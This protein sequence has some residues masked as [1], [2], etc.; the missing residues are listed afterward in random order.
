MFNPSDLEGAVDHSFFDSDDDRDKA[1]R[2]AAGSQ[3]NNA[4]Q[5]LPAP[6][7]S[8]AFM[9]FLGSEAADDS[10]SGTDYTQEPR[11]YPTSSEEFTEQ[12]SRKGSRGKRSKSLSSSFSH[13][14]SAG[15]SRGQG[16]SDM[17]PSKSSDLGLSLA[18]D[19]DYTPE[20]ETSPGCSP[21]CQ[22]RSDEPDD[23]QRSRGSVPPS[24][25]GSILHADGL[26]ADNY[27]QT[28][29]DPDSFIQENLVLHWRGRPCRKNYTFNN[30][31][32][33]RIDHENQRLLRVLSR[34]SLAPGSSGQYGRKGSSPH[35]PHSAV[36]R[37]R[38]QKRI[39]KDNQSLL[40]RL[41]YV[42]STP[43]L[44]RSNQLADY[45]RQARYQAT[46]C[47]VCDNPSILAATSAAGLS[48]LRTSTTQMGTRA[49]SV[50]SNAARSKML[51]SARPP[52]CC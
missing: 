29:F 48:S 21:F 3:E 30:N 46:P 1:A 10:D 43:Q 20:D 34:I 18:D 19:S 35:I 44:K 32:V 17:I 4:A 8:G 2:P 27:S 12:S 42:K 33:R 5:E 39:D 13:Y 45:Q 22:P 37:L 6:P 38:E 24:G 15:G 7:P 28:E 11:R 26:H 16:P 31:E 36:N 14:S 25:H 50:S 23:G 41:E 52:F 40:K 51:L 49:T 9:E 47:P